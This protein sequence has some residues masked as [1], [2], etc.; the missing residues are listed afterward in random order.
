MFSVSWMLSLT[1]YTVIS[2]KI[3]TTQYFVH[4]KLYRMGPIKPCVLV[5]TMDF[6]MVSNFL[7]SEHNIVRDN[8]RAADLLLFN[9]P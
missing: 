5:R 8:I 7:N 9:L 3:R 6:F 4:R 2:Q 1:L